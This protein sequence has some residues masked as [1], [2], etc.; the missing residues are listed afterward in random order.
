MPGKYSAGDAEVKV[1]DGEANISGENAS[2]GVA[3]SGVV[4]LDI[5]SRLCEEPEL[6]YEMAEWQ[7][8]DCE[9]G[10]WQDGGEDIFC[11]VTSFN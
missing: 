1:G 10:E 5:S 4:M 7:Y 3:E 8:D 11:C 6:L 9:A 2:L